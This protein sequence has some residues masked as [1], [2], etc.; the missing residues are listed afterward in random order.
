MGSKIIINN[1]EYTE[2]VVESLEINGVITQSN[3]IDATTMDNNY[4]LEVNINTGDKISVAS[5]YVEENNQTIKMSSVVDTNNIEE[6]KATK[7]IGYKS[8]IN[9]FIEFIKRIFK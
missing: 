8:L 2:R 3:E 7:N 6:S 9:R 4:I 1:K 5:S